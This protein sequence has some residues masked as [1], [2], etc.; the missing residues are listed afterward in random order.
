MMMLRIN[1]LLLTSLLFSLPAHAEHYRLVST[2]PQAT[3]ILFE[4]GF[5]S[6]VIGTPDFSS[7]CLVPETIA[8]V[9]SLFLPS[10]ERILRLK[11]DG[12]VLDRQNSGPTRDLTRLAGLGHIEIRSENL[13]SWLGSIKEL[14]RWVDPTPRL[15]PS[16]ARII[17]RTNNGAP[18]R[19]EFLMLANVNPPI[20]YTDSHVF[21]DVME[22]LGWKNHVR[23]FHTQFVQ[24]SKERLLLA[25]IQLLVCIDAPWETPRPA[26]ALPEGSRS[27]RLRT[28]VLPPDPYARTTLTSVGTLS[29]QIE[30]PDSLK[31]RGVE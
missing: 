26:C 13:Q 30:G 27:S 5:G 29:G 14:A 2:S 18:D 3:E 31:T 28:V 8:S 9:G 7:S 16:L 19:G 25:N 11:P 17:D 15:I 21:S 20:A 22:S 23:D 4:L 10:L 6:R 1:S 24:L 12:V